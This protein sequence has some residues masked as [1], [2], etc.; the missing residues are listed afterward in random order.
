MT[1]V[2]VAEAF[3]ITEQFQHQLDQADASGDKRWGRTVIDRHSVSLDQVGAYARVNRLLTDRR[4]HLTC[5]EAALP[6]VDLGSFESPDASHL[7]VQR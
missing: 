6:E 7:D 1:S 2:A 4:V 5:D 3:F